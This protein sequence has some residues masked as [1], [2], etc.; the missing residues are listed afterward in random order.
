LK[1]LVKDRS[2]TTLKTI[3]LSIRDATQAAYAEI[4]ATA[5]RKGYVPKPVSTVQ[6]PSMQA[7]LSR[8]PAKDVEYFNRPLPTN[9]KA[10]PQ[11]ETYADIVNFRKDFRGMSKEEI[12]STEIGMCYTAMQRREDRNDIGQPDLPHR[13]LE[14]KQAAADAFMQTTGTH[15]TYEQ[16]WQ[17]GEKKNADSPLHI[18]NQFVEYK[19]I[20]K[21]ETELEEL[22]EKGVQ[23]AESEKMPSQ[24]EDALVREEVAVEIVKK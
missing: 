11:A 22:F 3:I 12:R 21:R 20:V 19:N 23:K 10:N 4:V 2:D 24:E 1:V 13:T 9:W 7:L 8:D 6:Q 5:K 16:L 15:R 17:E 18:T 14:E